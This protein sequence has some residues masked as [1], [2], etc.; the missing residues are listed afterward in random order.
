PIGTEGRDPE[1]LR[2]VRDALE[3]ALQNSFDELD[4]SPWVV[5]FYAKDETSS[6]DYLRNLREYIRPQTKASPLTEMYLD[7]YKHHNES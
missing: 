2:K 5:Q 3:N 1:W 4:S 6:D 7:L